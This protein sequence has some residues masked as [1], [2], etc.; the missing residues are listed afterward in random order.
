MIA[1]LLFG[2]PVWTFVAGLLI[3]TEHLNVV[4]SRTALLD[5][6]LELWV[7]VGFFFLLLDRRWLERRQQAES[8]IVVAAE[9]L[10]GEGA[11]WPP[12]RL[13]PTR[14]WCGPG[15]SRREPRSARRPP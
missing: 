13:P 3:A 2:K 6:H 10:T 9:T 4:M 11:I 15:G 7:V 12:P 8:Q 1:Q 5:V 14:R